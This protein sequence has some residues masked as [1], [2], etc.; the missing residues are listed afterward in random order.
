MLGRV[1]T[2]LSYSALLVQLTLNTIYKRLTH[3]FESLESAAILM[4][5]YTY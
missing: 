4:N 5:L 2:V 1:L 3:H